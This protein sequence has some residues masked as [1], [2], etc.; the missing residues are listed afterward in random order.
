MMM[1][2]IIM[3]IIRYIYNVLNDALGA[4]RI[5]KKLNTILSK[6]IHTQNRQS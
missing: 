6:Y 4:S 5:H 3:I 2:I 1:I